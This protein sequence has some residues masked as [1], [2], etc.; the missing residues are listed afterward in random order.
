MQERFGEAR[1]RWKEKSENLFLRLLVLSLCFV[2]LNK[3]LCVKHFR[4]CQAFDM[5]N[6]EAKTGGC[7]TG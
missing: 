4:S 3:V 1:Q 7:A 2:L 6:D 5:P